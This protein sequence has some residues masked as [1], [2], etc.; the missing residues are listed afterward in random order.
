MTCSLEETD[1]DAGRCF[2]EAN[3]LWEDRDDWAQDTLA[4][5][6]KGSSQETLVA[7]RTAKTFDCTKEDVENRIVEMDAEVNDGEDVAST[8]EDA[9]RN[10][11]EKFSQWRLARRS[12]TGRKIA[13]G[14]QGFLVTFSDFLE[15]FSGIVEIVKGADQQYGGLAYGTLSVLLT[16]A[17]RKNQREGAIEDALEELTYAFPR[18]RI[19]KDLQPS[20]RLQELVADVFCLVLKFARETATYFSSKSVRRVKEA[21][22]PEKQKMKTMSRIRKQLHQ[23]KEESDSL[24]LQHICDMRQ[25]MEEMNVSVRSIKSV[26]SAHRNSADVEYLSGIR[27][28]LGVRIGASNLD[29]EKYKALLSRAFNNRRATIRKPCETT[30]GSLAEEPVFTEWLQ[31]EESQLLLAGGQNWHKHNTRDLNWLSEGSVL[32]AEHLLNQHDEH[33]G[34]AWFLCQTDWTMTSRRKHTMQDLIS[35]LTYQIVGMHPDKLRGYRDQIQRAATSNEWRSE[36]E[37][38]ALNAFATLLL[39][40]LRQ[41]DHR[42]MLSIVIDRLDQCRWSDPDEVGWN[43]RFA[44]EGFLE[45]VEKADCRVKIMVVVDASSAKSL[46]KYASRRKLVMK[47]EWQQKIH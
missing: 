27:T 22:K 46:S 38:V 18:L 42:F 2:R 37:E 34:V 9:L 24:L 41:F 17:V 3:D 39:G 44:I 8:S 12:G 16:V 32:L 26:T 29:L 11:Q 43:M 25:E 4:E 19:L 13:T 1:K 6:R 31:K 40:M 47:A 7:S 30:F 15:S 21:L 14:L 33:H 45:V 5:F 20:E 28:S 36:D 10:A 35:S 23:V